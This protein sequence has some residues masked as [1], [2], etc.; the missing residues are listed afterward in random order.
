VRDAPGE[1]GVLKESEGGR[2]AGKEGMMAFEE[3]ED[4]C[5]I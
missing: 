4:G 2:E 3:G 5:P 1:L